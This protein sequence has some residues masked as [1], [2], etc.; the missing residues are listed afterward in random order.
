MTLKH[1]LIKSLWINFILSK[2][3]IIKMSFENAQ[4]EFLNKINMEVYSANHINSFDYFLK[5]GIQKTI[6][7]F[8]WFDLYWSSSGSEMVRVRMAELTFGQVNQSPF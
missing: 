2:I 4:K 3:K 8:R 5:Q 6:D 7:D 1:F